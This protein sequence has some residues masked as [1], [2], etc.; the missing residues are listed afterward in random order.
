MVAIENK[1]LASKQLDQEAFRK[2]AGDCQR[3]AAVLFPDKLPN[4][5][6]LKMAASYLP[7]DMVGGDYYD[8][9]PINKN[10]FLLCVADV[11]GKVSQL[12]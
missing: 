6:H 12:R 9:V 1:K 2:G 11:S 4:T 8:Y 5:P 7:H 10:Q 3:C